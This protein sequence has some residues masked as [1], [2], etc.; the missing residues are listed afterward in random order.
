[1]LP[2]NHRDNWQSRAFRSA[3]QNLGWDNVMSGVRMASNINTH[4]RKIGAGAVGLAA[5]KI[6]KKSSKRSK[7][8]YNGSKKAKKTKVSVQRPSIEQMNNQNFTRAVVTSK[9]ASKSR[10]SK[11]SKS[12]LSRRIAAAVKKPDWSATRRQRGYGVAKIDCPLNVVSYGAVHRD[13][14]T[15]LTTR[16]DGGV[17]EPLAYEIIDDSGAIPI[18]TK[19]D[20]YDATQAT[21]FNKLNRYRFDAEF[22][23]KNVSNASVNFT[24][25][26]YQCIRPTTSTPV[27]EAERIYQA[28]VGLTA[29]LISADHWQTVPKNLSAKG[30]AWKLVKDCAFHISSGEAASA[31]F[32][33]SWDVQ[34]LDELNQLGLLGSTYQKGMFYLEYRLAGSPSHGL[35]AP[36]N[37]GFSPASIVYAYN[38]N[39]F[40]QYQDSLDSGKPTDAIVPY[41][42][43]VGDSIIAEPAQPLVAVQKN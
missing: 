29:A 5:M 11:K 33:T 3:V 20:L 19:K 26:L 18:S 39:E 22:N 7:K 9:P 35:L 21:I 41:T 24:L 16:M 31:E 8:N 40:A 6:A 34:N 14:I 25:S 15:D 23:I 17:A 43:T 4:K 1:M 32:H 28:K 13:T 27:A 12:K 38:I 30:T 37:V 10:S 2:G 36:G 42:L